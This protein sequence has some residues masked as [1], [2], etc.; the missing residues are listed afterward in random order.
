MGGIDLDPASTENANQF[1]RAERIITREQ[2]GL[3]MV[4]WSGRV[5]L[6]PPYGRD[7]RCGAGAWASRLI[8]DFE[9]DFIREGILL[10]NAMVGAKWFSR[11]YDY[12]ICMCYARIR[13]LDPA[14]NN[15]EVDRPTYGNA[16]VYVGPK[17]KWGRFASAFGDLGPVFGPQSL[18]ACV[19]P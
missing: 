13:F 1:V 7:R 4:P 2:D 18:G 10:V 16:I 14:R 12:P 15:E 8:A 19:E 3:R 17:R 11:L 5:W 6:N 9:N